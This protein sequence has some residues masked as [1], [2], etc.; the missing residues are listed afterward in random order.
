MFSLL[1]SHSLS[2][3][4]FGVSHQPLSIPLQGVLHLLTL[5]N[6]LP[7]A[8]ALVLVALCGDDGIR[9]YSKHGEKRIK[10][11][12]ELLLCAS[13]FAASCLAVQSFSWEYRSKEG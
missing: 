1:H 3:L 9:H 10:L 7:F 13:G 8:H 4:V 2:C 5:H 12:A 6:L 11:G